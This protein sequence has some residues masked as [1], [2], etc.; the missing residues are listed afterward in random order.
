[1]RWLVDAQ[2]PVAL[3]RLLA[4]L[5]HDASHVAD[6]GLR[7]AEDSPIWQKALSDNLVI[8]TKDD[9][10]QRRALLSQNAPVIVWLRVGNMRKKSL[11]ARFENLLPQIEAAIA[12]GERLV[13]VR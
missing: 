6:V 1:M 9:D 13:E 2:L 8:I 11:L 7:H 4:G 3:A 5:G 10:F 12:A